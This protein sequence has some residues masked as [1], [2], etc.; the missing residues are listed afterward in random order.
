MMSEMLATDSSSIIDDYLT[1]NGI[2][3]SSL[4]DS[5]SHTEGMQTTLYPK[6]KEELLKADASGAFIILDATV[7]T[8][9]A[10]PGESRTGLYFQRSTS[11]AR[12][13]RYCCFGAARGSA[14][15]TVSCRIV[16]GN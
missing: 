4:N 15:K 1:G 12:T 5:L 9:A 13:K 11:T 7:N 8:G 3:L 6:L 14:E 10:N 16:N 2:G